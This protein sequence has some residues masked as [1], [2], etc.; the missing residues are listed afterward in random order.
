MPVHWDKAPELKQDS[1]VVV[2]GKIESIEIDGLRA[3]MIVAESV[4]A[5][6]I[7]AQPYLFP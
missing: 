3:P 7:P 5:T 6:D 4:E 1:W 2:K